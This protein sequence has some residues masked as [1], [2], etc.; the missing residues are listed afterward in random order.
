MFYV[1]NP[2]SPII[3]IQILQTGLYTFPFGSRSK[4]FLLGDHFINSHNNS[5]GNI[6]ILLGEIDVGHYRDLKGYSGNGKLMVSL[7]LP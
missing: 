7:N 2:L 3:H 6:W 1:V 4:H 5:L